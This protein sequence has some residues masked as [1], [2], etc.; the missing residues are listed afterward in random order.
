MRIFYSILALLLLI[1]LSGCAKSAEEKEIK[2]SKKGVTLRLEG[3]VYPSVQEKIVATMDGK[4][5]K[6][7]VHPG[8]KVKKNQPLIAFDTVIT[9]FDIEKTQKELE[10]LKEFRRF[11]KNSRASNVNLALVN[12][13]RLNL[14]RLAKLR[15]RGYT[16]AKEIDNAKA[17]YAS[18]LHNRYAQQELR[19][20]K[21]HSLDERI[22][23]VVNQLHKLQHTLAM[24]KIYSDTS[25]FIDTLTVQPGDYVVKG[26][27]LGTLINI[28]KVVVK[29]GVAPGLLPF[30]KKGKKVKID[31]I[32]TPPY[33][34]EATISRVSMVIDPD[35]KR[36]TVEIE[37][38]NKNY[39]L[40]PGT[41]ALVTVHLTKE[42]QEFIK[43]NFID[44]PNKS[45]YEVKS[46][47]F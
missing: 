5:K 9:Q 28:D 17:I 31:F 8:D 21:L 42:E 46:Q 38:P 18:S 40:Q 29:A 37:I 25:G 11:V 3:E 22:S 15:A 4:I 7:F 16:D 35:F 13:N 27:K 26:S 45:L 2:E 43:K 32:T 41:K 14:E 36:M 33:H 30:V 23:L 47:N 44:N 20:E 39:L 34:T 12:I 19:R 10:Y 24:S 1:S 6:L